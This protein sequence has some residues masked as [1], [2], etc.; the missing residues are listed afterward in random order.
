MV[1]SG[2]NGSCTEWQVKVMINEAIKEY[3]GKQDQRHKE[4]SDKLDRN[5]TT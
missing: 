2:G 4:N 5:A 1:P 3:D